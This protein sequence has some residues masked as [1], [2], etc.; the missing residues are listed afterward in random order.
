[1]RG[2]ALLGVEVGVLRGG[3]K[4]KEGWV[5]GGFVAGRDTVVAELR[6]REGQ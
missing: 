1:M 6:R 4:G 2:G 5:D 3:R